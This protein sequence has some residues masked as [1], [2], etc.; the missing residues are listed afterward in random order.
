MINISNKKGNKFM[1]KEQQI[2]QIK[3]RINRLNHRDKENSQIVRKLERK[4][5]K[6]V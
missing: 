2:M 1:T 6:I 4:L 5:R 3:D